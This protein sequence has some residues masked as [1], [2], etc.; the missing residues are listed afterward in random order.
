M[1]GKNVGEAERTECG[2][3]G[4]DETV[5]PSWVEGKGEEESL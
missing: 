3:K 2:Q 5:S 1:Q 4:L